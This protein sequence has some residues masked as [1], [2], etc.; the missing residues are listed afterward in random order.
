[1]AET[2]RVDGGIGVAV[3]EPS[4][5]TRATT[6]RSSSKPSSAQDT[7]CV[8][9]LATLF[10]EVV[11]LLH[12]R[13]LVFPIAESADFVEQMIAGGA[14]IVFDGVSYE[15]RFG[16]GLLPPFL[17]PLLSIDDLHT[18]VAELLISR[19]LAPLPAPFARPACVR[20]RR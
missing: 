19:G 13:R 10:P 12:V 7:A 1:M 3:A 5:A 8:A 14:Q 15:T 18:K 16:A 4:A 20:G 2:T 9:D 11:T 6:S 17:F